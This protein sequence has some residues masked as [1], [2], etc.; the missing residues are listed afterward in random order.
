MKEIEY[1]E[2]Y[3]AHL[4]ILGFKEMIRNKSC[5][6]IYKIMKYVDESLMP[7]DEYPDERAE[8][9]KEVKYKIM[10]DS[11]V[12]Y[13][14]PDIED[15]FYLLL[16]TC[17]SLQIS[18]LNQRKPVL[19]RGGI[20]KGTLFVDND[21]VFGEGLTNAY[22]IENNIA[23]YPRIVFT[24]ALLSEGLSSCKYVNKKTVKH[25]IF[26]DDTDKFCVINFL[27][28][29]FFCKS[30]NGVSYISNILNECRERI[31]TCMDLSIRNK[32]LW[33]Y[34]IVWNFLQANA[35]YINK[36]DNWKEYLSKLKKEIQQDIHGDD[37]E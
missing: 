24:H 23:V 12:I 22:L 25:S 2:Y 3:V 17:Q 32:Y 6:E 26:V 27:A 18:L 31:D 10:S 1:E 29:D 14:K 9:F 36:F 7:E 4:D 35:S 11:I 33:L 30:D 37:N 28:I 8:V 15:S 5:E 21:I 20:T 34:N 13:I 19:L 16:L